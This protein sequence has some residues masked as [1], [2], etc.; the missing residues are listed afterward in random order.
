MNPL[1]NKYDVG[2]IV[3]RFQVPE[4]SEAH[5]KLIQSVKESHKQYIVVV[6]VSPTLG[7]KKHPLGYTT[8]M[9]MIQGEFPDAI[10]APLAD[11]NSDEAWSKNLDFLIRALCP[12]GSVCMYGG[13]DSFIKTYQGRYDTFEM[14]II[15]EAQGSKIREDVGKTVCNSTEFRRGIIFACQ[16]QYPKVFP[17]VDMAVVKKE[18][19]DFFVLLANRTH[20]SLGQFPGGFVDPSDATMEEAAK[21]ELMEELDVSV[22]DS[23]SYVGSCLIE[24]WRYTTPDERIMTTLFQLDY[25]SGSGKPIDEFVDSDWVCVHPDNLQVVKRGHR[26]LFLMLISKLHP[27]L[28]EEAFTIARELNKEE[29]DEK[30]LASTNR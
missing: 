3:G 22:G 12:I 26:P 15:N 1:A 4:L 2:V 9:Q 28:T 14:A 8:R 13:R 6:G 18:A 19:K 24:D 29:D 25:V 17:T 11:V 7:T 20:N 5:K 23:V 30:N 27:K 21:R 16:N 10:V